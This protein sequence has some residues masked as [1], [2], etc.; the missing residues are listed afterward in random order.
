MR[1]EDGSLDLEKLYEVALEYGL[2]E[3]FDK[4][5]RGVSNGMIGGDTRGVQSAS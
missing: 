3:R 1:G 2:E 4:L 5:T